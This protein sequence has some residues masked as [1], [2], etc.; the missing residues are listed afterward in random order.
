MN[1]NKL[2]IQ[3]FFDTDLNNNIDKLEEYLHRYAK[4]NNIFIA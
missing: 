2:N 4:K 1:S 3:K